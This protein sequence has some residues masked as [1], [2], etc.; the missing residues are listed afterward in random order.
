[1]Q[2]VPNL[3]HFP[4]ACRSVPNMA[5]NFYLEGKVVTVTIIRGIA[6]IFPWE[7]PK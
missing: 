4:Q 5:V 1:M 6:R 3:Q 7:G 2:I